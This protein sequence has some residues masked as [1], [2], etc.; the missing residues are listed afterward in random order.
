MRVTIIDGQ[1]AD[2]QIGGKAL[3]TKA[4]Y[5]IAT[6]NYLA[7]GADHMDALAKYVDYWSS[8]LLIRDLYLEAVQMQDTLRA[9]VDGRM[10]FKP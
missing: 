5:K 3:N 4:L 6:S 10:T 8:D 9:A 1:V 2:V 7:G